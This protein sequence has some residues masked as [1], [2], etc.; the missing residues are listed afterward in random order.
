M[1]SAAVNVQLRM[2]R[3]ALRFA[4]ADEN[5]DNDLDFGEFL[6]MQPRC[7]REEHSDTEI[8]EWFDSADTNKSGTVSINEFFTWTLQMHA[9]TGMDAVRN[10]FNKYDKNDTGCVELEEF[11]L[12]CSDLGFGA[13]AQDIFHELDRDNS[14]VVVFSEVL[15]FL[16]NAAT[17]KQQTKNRPGMMRSPPKRGAEQ[18]RLV[19]ESVHTKQLVMAMAWLGDNSKSDDAMRTGQREKPPVDTSRWKLDASDAPG[20][21][22][23]L[24]DNITATC[25]SVT[26]LVEI[27]N[28]E[29]SGNRTS[30]DFFDI[31]EKEFIKTMRERFNYTAGSLS[32]LKG[33]FSA[34]GGDDGKV[35]VDELFEFVT[36][37]TNAMKMR[38]TIG[39][40]DNLF[41]EPTE[42]GDDDD[43]PWTV[44]VLRR[45][46]QNMLIK[47]RTMPHILI[48]AWDLNGDHRLS[49]P[50]LRRE[51]HRPSM[52][53][54]RNSHVSW[55]DDA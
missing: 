50:F 6:K 25:A 47:N 33:A 9:L 19:D 28:W 20:L 4:E 13:A 43:K 15:A 12:L 51:H 55:R 30:A 40:L 37:R 3:D 23:Q 16:M 44:D 14:G 26:E 27:F 52:V 22:K 35:E 45:A 10:V 8:R 36:G 11:S 34:L 5:G 29:A 31:T 41:L 49:R 17:E 1:D 39:N 53:P 46:M 21:V 7:V 38:N 18:P 32:V 42:G 54:P 24:R 2:Q 48:N